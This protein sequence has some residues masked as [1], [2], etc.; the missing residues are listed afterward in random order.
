MTPAASI[1]ILDDDSS[2]RWVLERALARAGLSCRSFADA[3]SVYAELTHQQPKVLLT[4]IRMP[5]DDGLVVLRKLTYDYP[6]IAVIVMTAHS[7][8]DSAVSAFQGGAV[9]YLAKPFDIDEVVHT[10]SRALAR[11]DVARKHTPAEHSDTPADVHDVAN[12]REI[13]GNAPAMQD[14]FRAMGRLSHSSVTVLITGASGSGKE[15]V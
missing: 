13:I 6:N 4:D 14:V 11:D 1:W 5:G 8:L 15:L 7:D 10:V 3:Q 2:I 9:E 12:V